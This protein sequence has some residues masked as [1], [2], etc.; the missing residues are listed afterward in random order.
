LNVGVAEA[1]AAIY[2]RNCVVAELH[3]LAGTHAAFPDVLNVENDDE[4]EVLFGRGL[5]LWVLS[6]RP[7]ETEPYQVMV[8]E[9]IANE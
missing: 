5:M 1:F 4:L 2:G 8:A 7:H 3:V 6:M 9:E